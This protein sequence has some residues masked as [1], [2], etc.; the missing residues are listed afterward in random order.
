MYP[1]TLK[2]E[3]RECI[4]VG[5]GKIAFYKTKPLVEAGANVTVI[6]PL[7][8]PELKDLNQTGSVQLVEREVEDLD[9][10]NAFLVIAA[11][12]QPEI[13]RRIF[14]SLHEH[15][16]VN[17]VSDQELSNFH[18]PATL[19]RGKLS[20]SVSTQGASPLLAKKIRNELSEQFDDS[21]EEYLEFL[22]E[23]RMLIKKIE[24]GKQEKR[25]LFQESLLPKYKDSLKERSRF[26]ARL[27]KRK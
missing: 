2:I 16:L 25:L 24:I 22:M 18:I 9:Y 19:K 1:I 11:T 7:I 20:I 6:S 27:I 21:Y 5:G 13:N 17:S 8:C 10:D 15:R 14:D 12:D 26:L 4:V 23:S 3:N